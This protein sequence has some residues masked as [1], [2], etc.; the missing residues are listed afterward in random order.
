VTDQRVYRVYSIN[1]QGHF[2]GSTVI[3]AESDDEAKSIAHKMLNGT[4]LELWEGGRLVTRLA[5][6]S[7][8][9][10]AIMLRSESGL[11]PE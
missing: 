10:D 6:T 9:P 3:T 7:S 4:D 8:G 1:E 5:Q 11:V 2:A